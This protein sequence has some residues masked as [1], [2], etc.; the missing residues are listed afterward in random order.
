MKRISL[1]ITL[2]ALMPGLCQGYLSGSSNYRVHFSSYAF[3]YRNSGLV[4]GGVGFSSYAFSY[5]NP[6]LIYT[7]TRY[8]PY[9]L[10]CPRRSLI[11]DYCRGPVRRVCQV[12]RPSTGATTASGSATCGAATD[13]RTDGL[14]IIRRYLAERGIG[15]VEMNYRLSLERSTAGITFIL[16]DKKLAIRYRDPDLLAAAEADYRTKIVERHNRRWAAFAKDFEARGGSIYDVTA[17]DADAIVAALEA[18][19]A[20]NGDVETMGSAMMYA[21]NGPP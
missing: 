12:A 16:R 1:I 9:A 10:S 5:R 13:R 4:P 21:K 7:G 8:S 15:D 11:A 2:S 20:L 6:G 19:D 18:C 14:H 17:P 3:S